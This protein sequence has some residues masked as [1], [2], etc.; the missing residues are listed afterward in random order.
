MKKILELTVTSAGEFVQK[1]PPLKI[2][3]ITSEKSL[4]CLAFE[5]QVNDIELNKETIK[6][7]IKGLTDLL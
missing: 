5:R 6:E 7:L 4:P 3:I 2:A 1:R